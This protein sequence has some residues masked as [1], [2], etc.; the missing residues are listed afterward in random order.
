MRRGWIPCS[1]VTVPSAS[2]STSR[3][4]H[5]KPAAFGWKPRSITAST[6]LPAQSLR[7]R[8]RQL[9]P[10]RP[11]RRAPRAADGERFEMVE[12][13][14]GLDRQRPAVGVDEREH[15]LPQLA[16]DALLD[17][18]PVVVHDARLFNVCD[19]E[20]AARSSES[21]RKRRR[22]VGRECRRQPTTRTSKASWPLRPSRTWYDTRAPLSRVLK[23]S[24]TI[25]EKWTNRSLSPPS[26]VMNP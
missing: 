14:S 21:C 8:T 13:G 16:L 15:P 11:P 17:Q 20:S 22:S 1:G 4:S 26:G 6:R 3:P 12:V 24:S 18:V 19:N 25:T 2:R 23:P 9:E 7:A 10:R 5:W